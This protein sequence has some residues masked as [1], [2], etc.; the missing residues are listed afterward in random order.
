MTPKHHL[1]FESLFD[2]QIVSSYPKN[3]RCVIAGL[4]DVHGSD[5]GSLTQS[6]HAY[7]WAAHTYADYYARLF[8]HCRHAIHHVFECG[9]GTNNTKIPSSMGAL[10][11][12]GASLR[13]WRDYFPHATIHGADIDQDILFQEERIHTYH[14]DQ[15]DPTSIAHLWQKIGVSAFDLMIDDG[16]HTYQAGSTLFMHS[17]DRLAEHGI[18]IIED[19]S[20][21]D[22]FRYQQ[23]FAD[24]NYV[25]EY[26]CL[27]RPNMGLSDNSLIVIRKP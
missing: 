27:Y 10:G 11:K 2:H 21:T 3:T 18:Y 4:C 13:V 24:Q 15:L 20:S 23:F 14:L 8:S 6:G 26:V 19:V 17:I 7:P 22:L 25:V 5:K 1:E 9:L 16:L 12:P